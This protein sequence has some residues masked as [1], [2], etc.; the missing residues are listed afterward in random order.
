M[1]SLLIL[2]IRTPALL[3]RPLGA[4]DAPVV[5][6]LLTDP[7]EVRRA[8]LTP[9]DGSAV[10]HVTLAIQFNS[11]S[12]VVGLVGLTIAR[13]DNRSA[14]LGFLLRPSAQGRGLMHEALVW[15]VDH[16]WLLSPLEYLH[17]W[18]D[19]TEPRAELCLLR[20]GFQRDELAGVTDHDPAAGTSGL[21]R[22]RLARRRLPSS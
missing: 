4:D 20:M 15:F 6:L 22:Y 3:L 16:S 19:P 5:A 18:A 1:H 17:A 12:E 13:A 11:E 9:R 21:L 10:G 8:G 2:P 7:G 14:R